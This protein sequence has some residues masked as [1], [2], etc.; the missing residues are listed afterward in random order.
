MFQ[1]GDT[2]EMFSLY[3]SRLQASPWNKNGINRFKIKSR[4]FLVPEWQNKSRRK[5]TIDEVYKW[6]QNLITKVLV[7]WVQQYTKLLCVAGFYPIISSIHLCMFICLFLSL[8][9][10]FICLDWRL[11]NFDYLFS[12]IFGLIICVTRILEKGLRKKLLVSGRW[13]TTSSTLIYGIL[14]VKRSEHWSL[15]NWIFH[16]L[17]SSS[18]WIF[19]QVKQSFQSDSDPDFVG[20]R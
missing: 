6:I 16:R 7:I 9:D 18:M 4:I 12:S 20:I 15:M 3:T 1:E 13:H 5:N 8:I 2:I 14:S 11:W 19:T 10:R 17:V